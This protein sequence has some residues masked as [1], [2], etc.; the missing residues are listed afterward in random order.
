MESLVFT[1]L[2]KIGFRHYIITSKKYH[3]KDYLKKV[4]N[5]SGNM[6]FNNRTII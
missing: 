5:I 2:K 1:R 6:I 3:H 4:L